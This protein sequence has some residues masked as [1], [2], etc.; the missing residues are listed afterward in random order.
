MDAKLLA[1]VLGGF[2]RAVF[3]FQRRR[4]RALGMERPLVGAVA[5]VQNFT[6]ALLLH[7]HFHVLFPEGV[8]EGR[9]ERVDFAA[10]PPPDDADVELARARFPDGLPY[11][12]D[13]WDLALN[14]SAQTRLPLG[15]PE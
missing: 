3:A 1:Q 2:V 10:L 6:S 5:F 14:A 12:E 9:E 15:P 8:F 11:A 4:A 7:P 13:A